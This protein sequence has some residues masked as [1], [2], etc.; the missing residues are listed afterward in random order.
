MR[1]ERLTL[2]TARLLCDAEP[3]EEVLLTTLCES[4]EAQLQQRLRPGV[5]R[6]D[7]E[8]VFSC[9][10]AQL[11]AADLL[12]FRCGQQ[13]VASFHAGSLSVQGV[14]A[15][16]STALAEALRR[17]AWSAMAPYTQDT[18]FCARGVR[19]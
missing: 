5:S 7:C 10:A 2:Q 17:S 19:G 1:Q 8:T 13:T 16:K 12:L 3:S 15:Q 18:G 9:A 4:A 6:G 14:D 11:A